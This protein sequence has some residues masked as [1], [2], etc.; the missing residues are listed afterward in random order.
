MATPQLPEGHRG[1]GDGSA[2]PASQVGTLLWLQGDIQALGGNPPTHLL[3]HAARTAPTGLRHW[4]VQALAVFLLR[5]L[6]HESLGATREVGEPHPV[7]PGSPAAW[8]GG[9]A[10]GR[11]V[12]LLLLGLQT[13]A[14][15]GSVCAGRS[16]ASTLSVC[17][18][19]L[20][21]VAGAVWREGPPSPCQGRNG[22]NNE[23]A[24]PVFKVLSSQVSKELGVSK[25]L[26]GSCVRASPPHIA[27]C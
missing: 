13:G 8:G 22:R 7:A 25:W 1:H 24:V 2:C 11:F 23:I 15:S 3:N 5:V 9:Q 18:Q 19:G 27:R 21:R 16:P 20:G 14:G 26:A 17:V 6:W 12:C 4:G 10:R